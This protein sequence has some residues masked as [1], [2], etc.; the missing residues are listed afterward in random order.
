MSTDTTTE[1]PAMARLRAAREAVA[2]LEAASAPEETKL[3]AAARSG[4]M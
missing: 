4:A 2:E 1:T 3:L